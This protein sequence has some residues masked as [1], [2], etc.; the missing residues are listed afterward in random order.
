MLRK[1]HCNQWPVAKFIK[2][3]L[4]GIGLY[5]KIHTGTIQFKN[6]EIIEVEILGIYKV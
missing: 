5:C 1:H 2:Y 3:E 6:Y 4:S